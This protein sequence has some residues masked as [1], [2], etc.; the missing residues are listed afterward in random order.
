MPQSKKRKG[1]RNPGG[2]GGGKPASHSSRMGSGRK[3]QLV[4]ILALALLAV[5]IGLYF[6]FGR[7]KPGP[8][9][10]KGAPVID[11]QT[12]TTPS[13]LQY[14]DELIGDGPNPELGQMVTVHYTGT[15]QNGKKFDSS[16]DRGQ[17]YKFPIGRGQVIKGWD[18][19]LMTMKVGGKRRLIIPP[20]LGYGGAGRRPSIP[21]NATLIFEVELLAVND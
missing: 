9:D 17:P 20:E 12:I 19:G 4:A 14:V 10:Y 7:S 3:T 15:L 18:E 13:G 8:I 1:K 16:V 6:V 11:A 2:G 21:G 5:V